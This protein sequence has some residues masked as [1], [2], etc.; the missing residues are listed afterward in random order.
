M[1]TVKVP[2]FSKTYRN[3]REEELTDVGAELVNGYVDEAGYLVRMPALEFFTTGTS[4]QVGNYKGIY[5]LYYHDVLDKIIYVDQIGFFR[6]SDA[7]GDNYATINFGFTGEDV[8]FNTPYPH[9]YSFASNGSEIFVASAG[10]IR[11]IN[12]TL[13]DVDTIDPRDGGGVSDAPTNVSQVVYLDGYLIANTIGSNTFYWSNV[14]DHLTWDGESYAST[15]GEVDEIVAIRV[16]NRELYIFGKKTLEKWENDGVTPFARVPGGYFEVGCLSPSLIVPFQDTI[17][18]I[19]DK[20]HL[21]KISNESISRISTNIDRILDTLDLTYA[22]AMSLKF[23]GNWFLGFSFPESEKFLL[24]N[25]LTNDWSEIGYWDS[26]RTKFLHAQFHTSLYIPSTGEQIVAGGEIYSGSRLVSKL[27]S[28]ASVDDW[29]LYRKTGHITHATN[30]RKRSNELRIRCSCGNAET[31]NL[32]IRWRDD[33]SSKWSNEH[34]LS[35]KEEGNTEFYL[36]LQRTG[37][38]RSRQYELISS[39]N[40]PIVIGEAEEDIE[41]LAW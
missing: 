36:R 25:L 24:F 38:Y 14:N 35:L 22:S 23:R 32:S 21:T 26:E 29:K 20:R 12:S 4:Y 10:Y 13:T 33:G 40:S 34:F 5:G 1:K 27:S 37:I 39:A 9:F 6:K 11:I 17:Y 31:G 7:N 2:L 16:I 30:K 28:T 41:V 8:D 3:I 18:F 19:D 15:S